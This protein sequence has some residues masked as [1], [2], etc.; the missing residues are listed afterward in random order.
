MVG[1]QEERS[2]GRPSSREEVTSDQ[3]YPTFSHA[4]AADAAAEVDI[5]NN[6]GVSICAG[7]HYT[8][9][10]FPDRTFTKRTQRGY[11]NPI[12]VFGKNSC[13]GYTLPPPDLKWKCSLNLLWV[14]KK[15][16]YKVICNFCCFIKRIL[17]GTGQFIKATSRREQERG[18]LMKEHRGRWKKPNWWNLSDKVL[19]EEQWVTAWMLLSR[20]LQI[21]G[22]YLRKKLLYISY[23]AI[24]HQLKSVTPFIFFFP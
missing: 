24:S 1:R 18:E 2:S 17:H 7:S 6:P 22:F 21:C 9:P 13:S 15:K 20:H 14:Y 10:L 23:H 12:R 4:A 16:V 8:F 11:N 5:R 19:S 3:D